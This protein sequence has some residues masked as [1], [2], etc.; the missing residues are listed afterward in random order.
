MTWS[1]VGQSPILSMCHV[2]LAAMW[3]MASSRAPLALS[4]PPGDVLPSAFTHWCSPSSHMAYCSAGSTRRLQKG[5]WKTAARNKL[6][7]LDG[8]YD[9]LAATCGLQRMHF[10]LE[11]ELWTLA[12]VLVL[13]GWW[14]L[15][16]VCPSPRS[17][18]TWI[19]TSSLLYQHL[20]R[21]FGFCG[22]RQP[23][24]ILL[25]VC[26]FTAIAI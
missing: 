18:S 7:Y 26:V 8:E 24:L 16:G 20:P 6:S 19:K 11:Q 17:H 9:C 4:C 25:W 22:S 10:K 13:L 5:A 3:P 15:S 1:H 23:N 14:A 2:A 21:E 12:F